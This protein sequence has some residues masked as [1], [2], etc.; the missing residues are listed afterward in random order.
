MDT[1]NEI[2]RK[3]DEGDYYLALNASPDSNRLDLDL[4]AER[5]STA[6][7]AIAGKISNIVQVLVHPK[8]KEIYA[9][10]YELRDRIL[11]TIDWRYGDDFK[12]FAPDVKASAWIFAQR[13]LNCNFEKNQTGLP[14]RTAESLM[15]MGLEWAVEDVL[16]YSLPAL[17]I[18]L[19]TK[20]RGVF[21]INFQ[22]PKCSQCNNAR[23]LTCTECAGTGK[24]KSEV[25]E[26]DFITFLDEPNLLP[27]DLFEETGQ[28]CENCHGTGRL[29][30]DCADR[31]RFRVDLDTKP[32]SVLQGRGLRTGRSGYLILEYKVSSPRPSNLLMNVY[33]LQEVQQRINRMFKQ[34]LPNKV[35]TEEVEASDDGMQIDEIRAYLS[36]GSFFW[37]VLLSLISFLVGYWSGSWKIGLWAGAY[38]IIIVAAVMRR[39]QVG[40]KSR[41]LSLLLF[42]LPVYGAGVGYLFDLTRTGIIIGTIMLFVLLALYFVIMFLNKS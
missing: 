39:S 42:L 24:I 20:Q 21:E 36:C 30:C 8:D 34:V 14:V 6:Y 41:Y 22:L 38:I 40:P 17:P 29:P 1:I 27:R 19:A 16:N 9:V 32:G 11:Q 37:L 12:F 33:G 5:I 3:L 35:D 31:Y 23:S 2:Q 26:P 28:L 10:A 18:P 13:L 4:A 7:P 15:E 25:E